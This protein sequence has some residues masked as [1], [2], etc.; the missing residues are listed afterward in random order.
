PLLPKVEGYELLDMI[1]RGGM[2]VVYKAR[3]IKL[4]R[5]VA[6]KMIIAGERAGPEELARFRAEAETVARLQHPNIVQVYEIG[7]WYSAYPGLPVPFIALEFVDG[8]S[9][10]QQFSGTP[11]PPRLAA[12]LVQTLAGAVHHAHL[13][14]V[15]HRDLKPANVLLVSGGGASGGAGSSGVVSSR[16]AGISTATHDSP[17]THHPKITDFGLAKQL[18]DPS[19]YTP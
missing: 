16:T 11:Q 12:A 13:H 18:D 10:A 9:L 2:G 4:K 15:V 19:C 8:P 14:G 6:L 17:L 7:E 5:L 3:Q 1:G